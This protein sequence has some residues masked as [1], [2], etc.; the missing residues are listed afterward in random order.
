MT[1]Q[2]SIKKLQ[3]IIEIAKDRKRHNHS[4]S[5]C[6]EIELVKKSDTHCGNDDVKVYL[7]NSYS[8]CN[9]TLIGY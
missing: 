6:I 9:S 8:E 2:I 4:V 3:N 1:I 5:R 7:K